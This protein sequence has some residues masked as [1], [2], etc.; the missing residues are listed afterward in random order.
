MKCKKLFVFSYD[1]ALI[2]L[3]LI[4]KN[5][6]MIFGKLLGD[7]WEVFGEF[8]GGH[9]YEKEKLQRTMRKTEVREI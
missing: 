5:L 3:F 6:R 8:L 2:R 9:H 7:F 4:K 1:Y